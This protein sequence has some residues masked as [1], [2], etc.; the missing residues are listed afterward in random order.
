MMYY[1]GGQS[2]Y[3]LREGLMAAMGRNFETHFKAFPRPDFGAHRSIGDS[4][5]A[6]DLSRVLHQRLVREIVSFAAACMNSHN[7]DFPAIGVDTSSGPVQAT[8]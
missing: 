2:C 4:G 5:L 3:S 8:E 6:A 7:A 1:F